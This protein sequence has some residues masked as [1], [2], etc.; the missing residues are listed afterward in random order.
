MQI[1][2]PRR[3]LRGKPVTFSP[4]GG[5]AA[6]AGS[7]VS[8][9]MV[10]FN[11]VNAPVWSAAPTA[12]AVVGQTTNTNV[13]QVSAGGSTITLSW[14]SGRINGA[15][16]PQPGWL[17][18]IAGAPPVIRCANPP[19]ENQDITDMVL[20]ATANGQSQPSSAGSITVNATDV[21]W[22]GTENGITVSFAQGVS[23]QTPYDL[24]QH[25]TNWDADLYT[26]S[27]TAGS[28]LSSAGITLSSSGVLSYNGTSGTNI[29]GGVQ[30]TIA[31]TAEADWTARSTASG[32]FYRNNFS[33][34]NGTTAG[35]ET[36]PIA[37]TQDLL[38]SANYLTGTGIAQNLLTLDT[39]RKLSGVGSMK[40]TM[41]AGSGHICNYHLSFQGKGLRMTTPT[42]YC[43]VSKYEFYVQ[44][45]YWADPVN[46]DFDYGSGYGGKILQILAPYVSTFQIGE[47]VI[48]RS[49]TAPNGLLQGYRFKESGSSSTFQDYNSGTSDFCYTNFLCRNTGEDISTGTVAEK[50]NKLQRKHGATLYNSPANDVDIQH[51]PKLLDAGVSG[52]WMVIEAYVRLGQS[53]DGGTVKV[54]AAPYGQ[55]PT[56]LFGSMSAGLPDRGWTYSEST[57]LFTGIQVSNYMNSPAQYPQ[58][59]TFMCYDEIICSDNPINFPGGYSIPY[60]GTTTP[61]GDDGVTT[62]PWTGMS[63][64]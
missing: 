49:P 14:S 20:V 33:W 27:Q 7:S 36:Q 22:D 39:T 11:A 64:N 54:W 60:P 19:D 47:V 62:Y 34:K 5:F 6:A 38:D 61:K 58:T 52:G 24:T 50:I 18:F 1:S 4:E 16:V 57:Q 10:G 26:M 29:I 17:T 45:A 28:S 13:T 23:N 44:F 42:Q 63:P 21:S 31:D 40:M 9:T 3:L 30:V 15:L 32:V 2:L 41:P 51:V 53:G 8:A 25:V 37:T 35:T 46:R 48:R 59:E 43:G 56:L 12:T 55:A